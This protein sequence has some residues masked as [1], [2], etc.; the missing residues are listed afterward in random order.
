MKLFV[1]HE[2]G[3]ITSVAA[4]APIFYGVEKVQVDIDLE[5]W[6]RVQEKFGGAS[7]PESE[8][9]KMIDV[10]GDR[11]VV[12][13]DAGTLYQ[14]PVDTLVLEV[15]KE[16]HSLLSGWRTGR[17]VVADG[18]VVDNPAWT[19]AQIYIDPP[20]E[21]IEVVEPADTSASSQKKKVKRE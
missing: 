21:V 8:L 18:R 14:L 9:H 1:I 3:R 12:V 17:F 19:E 10:L 5:A 7:L 11:L 16:S 15:D 2:G 6:A 20:A 13:S 4:I